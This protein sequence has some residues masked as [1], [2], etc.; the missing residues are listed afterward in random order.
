MFS[1]EANESEELIARSP[2]RPYMSN[3]QSI[4]IPYYTFR[5][6]LFHPRQEIPETVRNEMQRDGQHASGAGPS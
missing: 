1:Y 4:Q 2:I 5:N 6:M 3:L